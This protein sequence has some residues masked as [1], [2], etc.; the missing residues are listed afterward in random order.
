MNKNKKMLS[1]LFAVMTLISS[2]GLAMGD[3]EEKR[4]SPHSTG[5]LI[6]LDNSD[7]G[8]YHEEFLN[9]TTK[10]GHWLD[11]QITFKKFKELKTSALKNGDL[12][13]QWIPGRSTTFIV[14]SRTLMLDWGR[15]PCQVWSQPSFAAFESDKACNIIRRN[16]IRGLA[17]ASNDLVT[18]SIKW[19]LSNEREFHDK[20]SKAKDRTTEI[21]SVI[22]KAGLKLGWPAEVFKQDSE[23]LIDIEYAFQTR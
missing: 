3:T 1:L 20:I 10:L 7:Y 8:I 18:L 19:D 14:V 23:A 17:V 6:F 5:N 15:I 4:S 13:V 12:T 21:A 22:Y 11:S 9:L 16:F 2:D